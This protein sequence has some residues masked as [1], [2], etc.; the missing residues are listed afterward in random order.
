MDAP[1]GK[2]GAEDGGGGGGAG[3]GAEPGILGADIDG[4][5]GGALGGA[6]LT[7]VGGGGGGGADGAVPDG[8]RDDDGGGGGGVFPAPG[9]GGGPR[10]GRTSSVDDGRDIG[11]GGGFRR[12]ATNGLGAED[13]DV[14]GTGGG[15]APGGLGAAPAGGLGTDVVVARG[16]T[17]SESERYDASF[18]FAPVSTPPRLRSLGIPPANKPPN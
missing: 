7:D 13:S 10:G 14:G 9:S 17:D 3:G 11:F 4:G 2:G 5:G 18:L 1:F 16:R 6:G 12:L 8:L 15:R